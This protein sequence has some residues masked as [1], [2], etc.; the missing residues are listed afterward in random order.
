MFSTIFSDKITVTYNNRAAIVNKINRA[1][2]AGF[3]GVP[4]EQILGLCQV[5]TS[6]H[7]CFEKDGSCCIPSGDKMFEVVVKN[8]GE[9]S[10]TNTTTKSISLMS[11]NAFQTSTPPTVMALP[12]SSSPVAVAP[13][14]P[15]A[16]GPSSISLVEERCRKLERDVENLLGYV[17]RA[18]EE[19]SELAKLHAAAEKKLQWFE[20][21]IEAIKS[22]IK[23][24]KSSIKD[25]IES[26]ISS[27]IGGYKQRV[28]TS[29]STN[30]ENK[31]DED[32]WKLIQGT[33][34]TIN[35]DACEADVFVVAHGNG[36][37]DKKDYRL[38]VLVFVD[39][40]PCGIKQDQVAQM[41][42]GKTFDLQAGGA[43][44]TSRNFVPFSVFG[45]IKLP[46]GSHT[47]D[48]RFRNG[49]HTGMVWANDVA[50]AVFLF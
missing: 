14:A 47:V 19:Y 23:D 8:A 44:C 39:E 27:C 38:D 21:G 49:T 29:M 36:K 12:L 25:K 3:F 43:L 48:V 18:R 13:S 15:L 10:P 31:T 1:Y 16:A 35:V 7:Y 9:S 5:G 41:D 32:I 37:V 33:R 6:V 11:L 34:Q 26:A 17:N 28:F 42:K 40:K 30:H 20:E 45:T 24:D 50:L 2:L 22:S 46:K 4:E